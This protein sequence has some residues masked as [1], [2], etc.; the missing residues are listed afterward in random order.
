MRR[1]PPELLAALV[2]ELR[3]IEQRRLGM[4]EELA[5]R[6]PRAN[7]LS[8]VFRGPIRYHYY[9]A[10]KDGRGR[11]VIYC[12]ST[13]RN[14][15]G[16]YLAWREVEGKTETKRDQYSASKLRYKAAARAAERAKK[17]LAAHGGTAR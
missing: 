8:R 13:V 2:P 12:Y 9:R 4:E 7:R 3:E 17:F 16:Y 10:G 14:V 1:L 6:A 15:S 11:K 5:Q